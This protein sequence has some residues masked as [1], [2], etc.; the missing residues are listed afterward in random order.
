MKNNIL[1]LLSIFQCAKTATF[2]S[3]S[4]YLMF[5]SESSTS[6]KCIKV[7]ILHYIVSPMQCM[8]QGGQLLCMS[9]WVSEWK[10][11]R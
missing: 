10:S 2:L 7:T 6:I 5:V 1:A 11:Q 9:E 8:A 4:D 3:V